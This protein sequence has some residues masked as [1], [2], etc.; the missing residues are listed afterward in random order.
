VQLT[1]GGTATNGVDYIPAIPSQVIFQPGEDSIVLCL[2]ALQDNVTEGLESLTLTSNVS[3]PCV[4]SVNSLTIYMSDFLPINVNAGPDTA[5]CTSSPITFNTSV[6]GGVEPYNYLWSNGATTP[7]ITV[8]PTVTTSYVV[9]VT[10]PCG[11][12]AGTDTVT[13]FLPSGNPLATT[14]TPTPPSLTLCS[15]DPALLGVT[16]TGGSLPYVY[17]WGTLAGPDTVPN[18]ASSVNTFTPTA[19]GTFVVLTRDGC[20]AFKLDTF[21]ISIHDCNVI[22][23]NVFTPNGDGVNDN[24]VFFGLENFPGTSLTVYNRWGGKIYESA[25]YHNDWNGGGVNDGTYYYILMEKDGTSMTGFLTII[26]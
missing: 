13:V 11:S 26:K 22:P 8:S 12:P 17:T 21:Q 23:P 9:V 4:Q 24:L 20:N 3:G 7:S 1:V 19:S 16:A 10:D 2:Q 18:A 6:T 5:L 15:G 14:T 25:D